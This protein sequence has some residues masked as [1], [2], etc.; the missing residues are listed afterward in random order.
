MQMNHTDNLSQTY[1]DYHAIAVLLS[2]GA[3]LTLLSTCRF[4]LNLYSIE[5]SIVYG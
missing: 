3:V 1:Q 5:N 4:F 2:V